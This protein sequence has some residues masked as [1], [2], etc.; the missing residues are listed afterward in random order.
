MSDGIQYAGEYT[1]AEFTL[2]S[3]S[4]SVIGI[5]RQGLVINIY[6]NI[7][8]PSMSG[9]I[10]F[11]DTNSFVKNLPIIGQEYIVLKLHTKGDK[12]RS[13]LIEQVFYIDKIT[14][15]TMQNNMEM[16]VLHFCS[17]EQIRN[18]RV[19][20]SQSYTGSIDSTVNTILQ[21]PKYINT[22]KN[23]FI[24]ETAG[25]RK[26]ISPNMNPF[27]FINRLAEESI[28]KKY[29]S[30]YFLFFENNEGIHFETLNNLYRRPILAE[31]TTSDTEGASH[32]RDVIDEYSR[33]IKYKMLNTND[34][35]SNIQGGLLA[36]KMTSYDI[37]NKNYEITTHGYFDDFLKHDRLS[38][39]P[40]YNTNYIDDQHTIQ[41]F[42][43]A[44]VNVHPK[45]TVNG[46]DAT[47][48]SGQ[49]ATYDANQIERS[50]M[51][52]QAKIME[53]TKGVRVRV[54]VQGQT[55]LSVGNPVNFNL[56][57]AGNPHDD[58]DFDPYYT[59]TYLITELQ[60]TFSEIQGKNHTIT[61]TL[62]KDGFSKELPRGNDAKEPIPRP[63]AVAYRT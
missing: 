52:R 13:G 9:E 44:K 17:P 3:S 20:V 51:D 2:F 12:S 30:P 32:P 8:S 11:L 40:I 34:M 50:L 15:R 62:F 46:K 14:G 6:E 61:M 23:L 55:N 21:S 39:I 36:S 19:R 41:D 1:N 47:Y 60:H 56:L 48:Y 42:P 16:F 38:N 18:E 7:Y 63:S 26:V 25:V 28:S 22:K 24:E 10:L 5:E 33:P 27:R 59:G 45:S 35:I 49:Q 29:N 4:G 43:D 54:S 58:S 37:F 57:T 31:Y 53:M